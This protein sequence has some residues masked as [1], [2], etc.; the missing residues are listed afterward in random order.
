MEKITRFTPDE[1][2]NLTAYL[3]GELDEKIAAEI[4]QKLTRSEVARRE[5]D[6]LSRTW[7]ML[8]L[9][10][11]P[12]V[13]EQFSRKTMSM[14]R[15][16]NRPASWDWYTSSILWARRV[17]VLATWAIALILVAFVGYLLTN[18]WIPEPSR[19]LVEELPLIKNLDNY[20]E[21]GDIEFL[22]QLEKHDPFKDKDEVPDAAN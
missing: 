21:I 8:S 1:R 14:A 3:D 5:V 19:Q 2:E 7:D 18:R 17:G 20:R 16:E 13:S 22:R 15:L 11:R 12:E 9:L 10:P 6:I 4:E